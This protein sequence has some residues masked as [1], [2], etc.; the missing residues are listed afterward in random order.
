M[1]KLLAGSGVAVVTA[2]STLTLTPAAHA[3]DGYGDDQPK[4][5]VLPSS[6]VSGSAAPSTGVLPSTGGP[7]TGLLLGGAALLAVGGTAL[8]VARRRQSA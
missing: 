7:E 5:D 3:A 1:K 6:D 4:T 2:L 8:V